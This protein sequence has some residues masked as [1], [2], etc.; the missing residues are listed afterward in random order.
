VRAYSDAVAQNNSAT[1]DQPKVVLIQYILNVKL[2]CEV[3]SKYF[4]D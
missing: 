2:G 3:T 4:S 1:T